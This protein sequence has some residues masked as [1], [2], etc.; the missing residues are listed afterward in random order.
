MPELSLK[1]HRLSRL[2]IHPGYED[3][4]G[5]WHEGTEEWGDPVECHAVGAGSANTI[6]YSDGKTATYS[7]TVGRL[8]NDIEEFSIGERVKLDILGSIG[9]YSVKGFRRYQLQSKIWV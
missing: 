7:Y 2:I 4:D 9:E 5:D 8:P 1:P 6:A 3:G